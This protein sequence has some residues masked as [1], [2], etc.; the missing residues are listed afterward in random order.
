[1]APTTIIAALNTRMDYPHRYL[2]TSEVAETTLTP[3]SVMHHDNTFLKRFRP[4]KKPL[5]DFKIG[6]NDITHKFQI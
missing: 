4:T 5:V 3:W 2:D 6:T 1:M